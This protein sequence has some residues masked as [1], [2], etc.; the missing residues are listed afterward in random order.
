MAVAFFFTFRCFTSVD[1][2]LCCVLLLIKFST[3]S[4]KLSVTTGLSDK[5]IVFHYSFSYRGD[6]VTAF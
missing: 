5:T 4:D 6:V 3:I 2:G 1:N